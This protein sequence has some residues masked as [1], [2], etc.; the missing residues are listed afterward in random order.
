MPTWQHLT[1]IQAALKIDDDG[2]YLVLS[3]LAPGQNGVVVP[4]T[5]TLNGVVSEIKSYR[6]FGFGT[7]ERVTV[8][9]P[10]GSQTF[11]WHIMATGN[12][13]IGGPTDFAVDITRAGSPVSG[14]P[15]NTRVTTGGV[16]K[17]ARAFVKDGG[18]W[19]PAIPFIKQSGVWKQIT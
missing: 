2:T 10:T 3:I 7:W 18:V 19:K 12:P 6:T 14:S 11:T 13:Y 8:V 16:A 4:Y 15:V 9:K 17:T 5:Y 1:G